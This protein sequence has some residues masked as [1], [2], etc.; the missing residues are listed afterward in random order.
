MALD[1]PRLHIVVL[2]YRYIWLRPISHVCFE[3]TKI[4]P[5]QR[6][7]ARRIVGMARFS[8]LLALAAAVAVPVVGRP[9]PVEGGCETISQRKAWSVEGPLAEPRVEKL[10]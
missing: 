1:V 10:N 7:A 6:W 8:L 3:N 9:S 2:I 4:I 5:S